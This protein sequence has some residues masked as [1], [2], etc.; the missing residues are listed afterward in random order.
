MNQDPP[1]TTPARPEDVATGF[2]L[3]LISLPLLLTGYLVDAF[4]AAPKNTSMLIHAITAMF[5]LMLGA[6][7]LTF[8][9]L[10]RSGYRWARTL[11]SGGGISTI[12]YTLASLFT[13]SRQP[14]AA[15]VF[16]VTG[17]V[18]SVL[19][20]GGMYLLHRQDGHGFFTR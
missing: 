16:A 1:A 8:L 3:W 15:I 4:T 20:G 9:L 17:I 18:G 19:I 13:V 12:I 14:V 10:M 6:L 7:V 2:W 5:A 11:L